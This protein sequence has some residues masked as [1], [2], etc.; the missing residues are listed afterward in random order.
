[1][2]RRSAL[3]LLFSAALAAAAF[4]QAVREPVGE[5]PRDPAFAPVT[6][7]PKLPRVLLIGD[8]ISIGYT[9]GVREL[10]AGK[11]NVHRIPVNGASTVVGLQKLDA[12]LGSGRWDVIHFNWGLHDMKHQ[13]DGKIDP[14]GPIW[15]ALPDYERNLR[16]L[17]TRLRA[18]G[19]KLIW[20]STT[21]VPAGATGRD[22]GL[23]LKYNEAAARVMRE[24]GV[25][26]NDLHA[27]AAPR[28]AELQ[29]VKDVHFTPQGSR[30][31]A[32]RVAAAIMAHLPPPRNP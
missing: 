29:R 23:E 8:S 25:P 10:L 3:T 22:A 7:D 27:V 2:T 31:L 16:T 21:P 20:A 11:A 32:E 24:L 14:L 1:M 18:T 15:V 5:K 19:A 13:R 28:L 17:V 12:W 26:I 9:L 4:A 30:A 6:D